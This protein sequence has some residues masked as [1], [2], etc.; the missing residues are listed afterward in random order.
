MRG[1]PEVTLFFWPPETPLSISLPTRVSAQTSR[2]R[3]F[4]M[5]SVEVLCASPPTDAAYRKR[6]REQIFDFCV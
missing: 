3:T 1:A 2:P 4:S 6:K 5:Y